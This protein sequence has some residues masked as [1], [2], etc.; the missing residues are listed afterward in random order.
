MDTPSATEPTFP[1]LPTRR[2]FLLSAVRGGLLG[3]G[4]A[5]VA[6]AGRV[7]VGPNFHTV[8]PGRAYR[9]AQPSPEELADLVRRF[10]IRTIVN[11]RGHCPEADWYREQCRA[12]AR[13]DIDQEDICFSAGRLPSV[14]E[15]RRLVEALD[16]CN[17]PILFHCQ[18]GADRTGLASAVY[19]LLHGTGDYASARRRLGLRFGHVALGRPANLDRFFALYEEWLASHAE[20]HTPARFRSWVWN[21]YRPGACW[22]DI[23]MLAFPSAVRPREPFACRVRC[24]NLSAEAWH[25]RPGNNAGTHVNFTALND[26]NQAVAV[27]KAGLF[28]TEV[29]PGDALDLTLTIPG[30]PGPG[31]YL[32]LVDLAEEQHCSYFQVGSEPMEWE[33]DVRD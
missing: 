25:F 13:L 19:L 24:R 5:L 31:R 27:G 20:A 6:E 2:R 21:D 1:N 11:L 28:H 32:L 7:L 4:L 26:V 14:P 33:F 29:A 15:V 23:E 16:H 9:C 18:R 12:C 22:A 3:V 8:D 30:L 17:Y 10:S